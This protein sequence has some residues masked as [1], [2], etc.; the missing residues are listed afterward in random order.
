[1]AT[2]TT[3]RFRLTGADGGPLR[4]DVRAAGG[5][6]PAVVICH[7]FKGFKDWGYFPKAAERLA[8]SGFAAVSFNFSGAGVGEDG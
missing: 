6:R 4:G 3:T 7:G 2:A 5:D 8:R 1:M